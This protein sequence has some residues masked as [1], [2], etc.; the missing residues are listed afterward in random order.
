MDRVAV[1]A[2]EGDLLAAE[3]HPI[4]AIDDGRRSVTSRPF[5]VDL[6]YS[7]APEIGACAV[8]HLDAPD[9]TPLAAQI[10]RQFLAYWDFSRN[11]PRNRGAP[12]NLAF[13]PVNVGARR[14]AKSRRAIGNR[15]KGRLDVCR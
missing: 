15:I 5:A 6:D 12:Q 8:G 11:N 2:N 3:L 14:V 9:V 4:A 7:R 1:S 13:Y 10:D